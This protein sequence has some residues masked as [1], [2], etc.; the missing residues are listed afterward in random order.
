MPPDELGGTAPPR[1]SGS[2]LPPSVSVVAPF[3]IGAVVTFLAFF[4][5]H[6]TGDTDDTYLQARGEV[7]IENWHPT[8]NIVI[9]RFVLSIWDHPAAILALQCALIW[10][11]L[12]GIAVA[13]RRRWGRPAARYLVPIGFL[14]I[15]FNYLG[16]LMK[17]TLSAGLTV[18]AI[19]L[20]LVERT[21]ARHRGWLLLGAALC[22]WPAYLVKI[23]ALPIVVALMGYIAWRAGVHRRRGAVLLVP[24]SVAVLAFVVAS[25]RM[26]DDALDAKDAQLEHALELFDLVGI[27]HYSETNVLGRTLLPPDRLDDVV[28]GPCYDPGTWDPMGWRGRC[29]FITRNALPIW[30]TDALH[31]RWLDAI[32][33]HPVDYVRHRVNHF[34][35]FAMRPGTNQFYYHDVNDQLEWV[36]SHNVVMDAYDAV[37]SRTSTWPH[38]RAIFWELTTVVLLVVLVR[39]RRSDRAG[40][41]DPVLIATMVGNLLFYASWLV[42]G[43]SSEFRYSYTVILTCLIAGALLLAERLGATAAVRSRPTR[44]LSSR[45]T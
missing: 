37:L 14:P 21:T 13:M 18:V 8:A 6:P 35:T 44:R 1:W 27:T 9:Y 31:Q 5:G 41:F 28:D 33:A 32:V 45:P 22:L 30:D 29:S 3:A 38:T 17:D 7:P 16:A 11:G 25:P 2:R 23:S 34:V 4:P 26:V 43:V 40:P 24:L 15:V 10:G 20:L 36:A 39:R 42:I 12:L 19:A